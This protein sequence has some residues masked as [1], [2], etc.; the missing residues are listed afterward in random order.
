[1]VHGEKQH[2][3]DL[4]DLLVK[5]VIGF[6]LLKVKSLYI[7]LLLFVSKWPARKQT[8]IVSTLIP[9]KV[10]HQWIDQLVKSFDLFNRI[11]IA[12][13]FFSVLWLCQDALVPQA[14]NYDTKNASLVQVDGQSFHVLFPVIVDPF[15]G[16]PVQT[17]RQETKVVDMLQTLLFG[18]RPKLLVSETSDWLQVCVEHVEILALDDGLKQKMKLVLQLVAQVRVVEHYRTGVD[19]KSRD[20]AMWE[21]PAGS[22][23][24]L[25]NYS[26]NAVV[27]NRFKNLSENRVILDAQRELGLT[28][29]IVQMAQDVDLCVEMTFV[30]R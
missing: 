15:S 21:Q 1:M 3:K 13:Q 19:H 18:N 4:L 11:L 10:S 6:R 12:I 25:L 23:I 22:D 16:Q 9:A 2:F 29:A 14:V 5:V 8:V 24:F 20:V 17:D 26:T 7:L 27:K 28:T 30:F